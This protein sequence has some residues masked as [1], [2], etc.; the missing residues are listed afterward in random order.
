MEI[1]DDGKGGAMFRRLIIGAAFAATVAVTAPTGALAQPPSP[2]EIVH[3][4]DRGVRH[5]AH[6][7]D[8]KIRRGTRRTRRS[9][10]RA[11]HRS[12]RAM[13]NDGRVHVGRTRTTA[14]VG[15][16]GVR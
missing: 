1:P 2:P 10:R 13:C 9:V 11:S 8:H 15:H 3:K 12:V 6:D 14:C 5:V 4:V 7:V 16:G